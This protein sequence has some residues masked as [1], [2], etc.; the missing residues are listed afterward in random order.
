MEILWFLLFCLAV[1]IF[2]IKKDTPSSE[3]NR[4]SANIAKRKAL[5]YD[6][7]SDDLATFT[8]SYGYDEE[9]SKNRSIGKWIKPNES[10]TVSDHVITGGN[11]YFGGQLTSLEGYN[12]EAS[13]VD[14]TLKT[15][16]ALDTFED[17]S[18][19]YWPKFI[20]LSPKC[21]GAYLSW[22]ASDRSNP[23][24]PL[25]YVFIYF[26]GIERRILV[27]SK[28]EDVDDSEYIQLFEEVKRLINVYRESRSFTGYG[29]RLLELMCLFRPTI[30][31]ITEG[32]LSP[33]YDSILFKYKLA[34]EVDSGNPI[35]SE[36]ALAWLRF[37]PDYQLRTPA[38]RCEKEFSQL[39][40]L[41]YRKKNNEG[42]VV[43]PNK[44][45]LKLEYSPASSSLRGVEIEQVDLPDP[46][47]LKTPLK[48]LISIADQSTEQLDAY[49]RY[50]GRADASPTDMAAQLLLPDELI[51]SAL[52]SG[53]AGFRNWAK[54]SIEDH[55]GLV[56]FEDYWSHT[57][58]P[59][60]SKVNK[61]ELELIQNLAQKSGYGITPDSRYHHA[62]P[63]VDGKLVLFIEGHGPYFEPSRAFN[64][65]G[66]A[67][68]LGAMVAAIDSH[69]D[70]TESTLL[71]QLIDHDSRLSPTE[72][73]SLSA[74]LLWRLNTKPNMTVLKARVENLGVKEKA[75]VSNILIGVALADG[76]IEPEEIKQLEKLYATLG[77]D[78]AHVVRD[79]HTASS[80]TGARGHPPS[81]K[82]PATGSNEEKSVFAL[83]ES[84]LAIHK[85]ETKEVQ[86]MLGAIFVEEELEDHTGEDETELTESADVD[87]LDKSHFTLFESLISKEKWPRSYVETMCRNLGL[88]VDGALETINDWSY[89]RV[90]ASV[91]EDDG[92]EIYVDQEIV[93]ELES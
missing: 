50:L 85:A 2:F 18:L 16:A 60:P 39:F 11:F 90:D 69:V 65:T 68:R 89:D 23:K 10:I 37:Y 71:Q 87:G 76:K 21:R 75:I 4:R 19:G 58:M 46:S 8:I 44:T 38:R 88:M 66:M 67:L 64:E 13:L 35:P 31:S 26:Y 12:K 33:R 7:D 92:D 14:E 86:T 83:D 81:Q 54:K 61:K 24:T 25:G 27:D 91:V 53:I 28:V 79:I 32:V 43:K 57:K 3:A 40:Q 1:Y 34:T 49:S 6:S 17:E 59:L 55:G 78:K 5:G 36:L 84:I 80:G 29:S 9:E 15:H 70:K 93:E 63:S 73:R 48:K 56:T 51:K 22:L 47:N 20:T 41:H 30:V 45:R 72:K 52:P 74:Y 62:K 77:L 82:I 42:L